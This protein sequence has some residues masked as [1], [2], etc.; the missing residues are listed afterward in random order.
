MKCKLA[1]SPSC[2]RDPAASQGHAVPGRGLVN[3]DEISRVERARRVHQCALRSGKLRT[4][5]H[6]HGDGMAVRNHPHQM[7]GCAYG[8]G[9]ANRRPK[10]SW[11]FTA[12][13]V[14]S[15]QVVI[16]RRPIG[17]CLRHRGRLRRALC[18]RLGR[19]R[20]ARRL[21]FGEGACAEC[22]GRSQ[23]R[24][25]APVTGITSTAGV[26]LRRSSGGAWYGFSSP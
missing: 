5:Y 15:P 19:R 25:G 24:L 11:F 14:R 20:V 4:Q 8:S 18:Y 2:G 7:N 22:M 23:A 12:S 6:W 10:L 3:E 16:R 26:P 21:A 13:E 9:E 1:D 17:L